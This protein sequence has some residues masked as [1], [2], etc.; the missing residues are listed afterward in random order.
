MKKIVKRRWIIIIAAVILGILIMVVV[1]AINHNKNVKNAELMKSLE[2]IW[3]YD[4]NTK[5]EFDSDGKGGMYIG[6][7]KYIYTFNVYGDELKM[8]FEDSAVHDATYNFSVS[9]DK[10]KL[11]GGEG[12]I[13]GEYE[14][15]RVK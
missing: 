11:I 3:I 12:T 4:E 8:D 5:Y 10:L 15:S 2:G 13:G 14:L 1:L 9:D 7:T 6:E